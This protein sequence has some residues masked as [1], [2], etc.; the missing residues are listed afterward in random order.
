MSGKLKILFMGTPDFAVYALKAL[1]ESGDYDISVITQPDKPKGR[2]YTLTPPEVKVYA[3]S[4]G[5][6]IY[7]PETLRGEEF[8][9]LLDKLSPDMIVVAAYGKILPENVIDYPKY[10]CINI[11]GSLLPEYRGAAPIQRAI[12]DGK[13]ESGITIMYM[14]AGLDTGD[15]LN[16]TVI[17]IGENDNFE[18]LFDKL[19]EAGAE[20]LLE[21][22]PKTVSGEIV[23][24]KQDD[25]L[26]TYA[27]K[28]EKN[29]CSVDFSLSA[30]SVHDLIRGLS[31]FPLGYA[32]K[33]GVMI[34]L[35]TSRLSEKTSDMEAGSIV[36][37]DGAL[38]VVC[39]DGRCVDLTELLPAGKKRM[40]AVDY[41]R[42]N[43]TDVGD[44]F[45][46][47]EKN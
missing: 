25:S 28:I 10:G 8:A 26:A 36:S 5:L 15:M 18:V 7:Q 30:Q 44:K 13:K 39:G 38:T 45:D 2:G 43:K 4:V 9:E 27:K 1:V 24:E 47:P 33:N 41:L 6:S 20:L 17:Q 34:K 19:A 31:P 32:V 42:G 23:P 35:I 16:K 21:T 3:E 37:V 22:V 12:I 29:D 14:N 40:S 11:H 46:I